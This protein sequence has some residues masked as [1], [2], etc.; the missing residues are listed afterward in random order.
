MM[1]AGLWA[2]P[3]AWFP[4][5]SLD[6]ALSGAAAVIARGNNLLIGGNSLEFPSS[7]PQSL[8]ATNAYWTYLPELSGVRIAPGAVANGGM[9]IV[10]GGSDGTTSLNTVI[11]YSPSGDTP[12][13][14]HAMSVARSF[15]GYAPDR[16]GRA[17]ALGGLDASGQPLSSAERYDEDSNSWAPIAALPNPLYNFPAIFDRTNFI[18]VFGGRTNTMAGS[19]S[20]AVLRYSI[21]GNKWAAMT[22]MPVAVAGSAAALGPDGSIYVA[23]GALGEVVTNV[24][25]IYDSVANSWTIT[26]PLPEGLTLAAMGVD[27]LGRLVVMG[28]TDSSGAAV[29]DVWR[30]QRLNFPDSVPVFVTYPD[31]SATYQVQYV[32][33]IDATGNPPPAYVLLNG[34]EGM[35]V[36]AYNGAI[37]W[38]PQAGQ[39]GS[40]AVTIR[41]TIYAGYVDWSFV[42]AVP[43]P[44]PVVPSGL[45][46]VGVTEHSVTLSWDPESALFG[47]VTYSVHLR[48]VLHDPKGSGATIWYT[49]IGSTTRESTITLTGLTPGLTQT[50]YVAATAPGGTSG[51]ASITATTLSP[52]PPVHL[53]VAGL[54][55]TSITLSWDPSPGPVA[56]ASYEIWGWIN[57]GVTS[58]SYGRV[59]NTTVTITGLIPG[60]IHE[61]GVRA[62]D[63]EGYASGFNYGPT[64]VNPIPVS[65]LLGGGASA[66]GGV[67]QFTSSAGGSVLQ[68][69][70]IQATT[71][72]AD[73]NA[74]VEIGSLLPTVSPFTFTDTNASVYSMRFYRIV[75]P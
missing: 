25:Q 63:A 73:P 55:S 7:Y 23:G 14:L 22:P 69:V 46:V 58:A 15:L 16:S 31:V 44:P 1:S 53:R 12:Q 35:A 75:A 50:Y 10:Y 56:I 61:W 65:P 8:G 41:A 30:S 42:I 28:G 21:S 20:A 37:T 72:L 11:G 47:P 66:A 59:T 2:A 52:Q 9:V 26:T 33:S 18:Y 51:Y 43:Y 38:I 27:S 54:T 68:T 5:P 70:L 49:Q 40:N 34:P 62:Y 6:N 13:V 29:G 48:H 57:N 45:T 39:I 60:S 17:Y 36:D 64:V 4:G 67:F 71:N 74:W 32:S 24:V 19:E 3:L